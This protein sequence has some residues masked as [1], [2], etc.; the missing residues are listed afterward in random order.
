LNNYLLSLGFIILVRIKPFG[1]DSLE[2]KFI[3]FIHGVIYMD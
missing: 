3:L 2:L 1:T